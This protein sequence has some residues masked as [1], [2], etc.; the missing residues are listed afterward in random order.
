MTENLTNHLTSAEVAAILGVSTRTVD[1]LRAAGDL[2]PVM[3]GRRPNVYYS[4]AEVLSYLARIREPIE[5][6]TASAC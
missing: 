3:I 5:P 4:Q 1:R 6:P 2:T